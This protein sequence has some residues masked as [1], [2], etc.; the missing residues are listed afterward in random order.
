MSEWIKYLLFVL[1]SMFAY[2]WITRR[3]WDIFLVRKQT[4]LSTVLPWILLCA[5]QFVA[6]Y[7]RN[8]TSLLLTLLNTLLVLLVVFFSYE[9]KGLETCFLMIFFCIM[10][11]SVELT[12]YTCFNYFKVDYQSSR[13]FATISSFILMMAFI[14]ILSLFSSKREKAPVPNHLAF[15]LV[16]IP[17]GTIYVM[18]VQ[19]FNGNE[20]FLSISVFVILL[21]FNILCFNAYLKFNRHLQRERENAVYAEQLSMISQNMEEQ[22]KL[23]EEFYAQ[24]HDLINELTVLRGSIHQENNED[25]LQYLDKI[26][27]CYHGMGSISSSDNSTVDAIIN[28]KYAAAKKYGISFHL[29]ISVPEELAVTSRDLGVVIGNALDN[30]ITAA[31]ECTSAEK[32][33]HISLGIKKNALVMVMKNPY[34]HILRQTRSGEFLTT[35]PEKG[36]HG[37]G[38]RSIRRIA[39]TY[40]G[41][42]VI[43]ANNGC[44]V[45]TV[46]LNLKD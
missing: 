3:F 31:K 35:K 44:F 45:L 39:D 9:A 8:G 32:S 6:Q 41:D 10:W 36:N 43:D 24:K 37:Y 4:S 33:I 13:P 19:H 2:V 20:D 25:A 23:M 11:G 27:N 40:H 21:L 22:K 16:I 17:I 38:I 12:L 28:A 1:F 15:L 5:F 26:L 30:A 34:E 7:F 14:H 18:F 42:V 29:Q 46:V